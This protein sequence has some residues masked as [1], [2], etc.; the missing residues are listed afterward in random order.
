M[1]M[2]SVSLHI[3]KVPVLPDSSFQDYFGH[4]F[5]IDEKVVV[6]QSV[7]SPQKDS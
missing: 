2:V 4:I 3:S 6:Q 1:V 7:G 5:N